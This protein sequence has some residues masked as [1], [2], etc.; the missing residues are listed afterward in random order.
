MR[1]GVVMMGSGAF[2]AANVGVL[3]ELIARG[4]E[5][6]AVCGLQ[7]GA[8]P[9]A[10]YIAGRDA[11]GMKSCVA[12]AARMGIRVLHPGNS[13]RRIVS[14]RCAAMSDGKRLAHLLCAQ[15][16]QRMLSACP[17]QGVFLCRTARSGH[18]MILTTQPYVQP[19]GATITMQCSVSF[20]ARAALAQPPILAPVSWMGSP[21]LP[22][23]DPAL[24]CRQLLAMGAQRV[25]LL[26]P[27]PAPVR[28]A[29]ALEL[30]ALSSACTGWENALPEHTGVLRIKM[31]ED[32]GALSFEQMPACMEAGERA[33]AQRIDT[34]FDEIG[35]SRCRI[36]P[37]HAGCMP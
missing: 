12:Q 8:W 1:L 17:R 4:C 23:A 25:L 34:L 28:S 18:L 3:C 36:L 11:A 5:P 20:A 10:L 22:H 26:A 7:G 27:Q 14:G 32:T 30:A 13:L 2:A 19:S 15:A 24:A 9:A 37:F 33:A 16:G 21:I 29:D 31:P 35:L 6:C